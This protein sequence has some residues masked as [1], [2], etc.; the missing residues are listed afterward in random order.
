[1][2]ALQ[3][4]KN[5]L[6]PGGTRPRYLL[7]LSIVLTVELLFS[8]GR[9]LDDYSPSWNVQDVFFL[10]VLTIAFVNPI[11]RHP[12]WM[13]YGPRIM[14]A[15]GISVTASIS[16]LGLA[17]KAVL[18]YYVV[19]ASLGFLAERRNYYPSQYLSFFMVLTVVFM[20]ADLA[21][22]G[23]P[24]GKTGYAVLMGIGILTVGINVFLLRQDLLSND[25][26][27]AE[28]NKILEDMEELSRRMV[29][30][31]S[32]SQQVEPLMNSICLESAE[33]LRLDEVNIHLFDSEKDSLVLVGSSTL[34]SEGVGPEA[35][36]SEK[37]VA[38][39]KCYETGKPHNIPE[40][41]YSF[42]VDDNVMESQLVVPIILEDEVI[43][44]LDSKHSVKGFYQERHEL[45][46]FVIASFC[47]IKIKE[48]KANEFLQEAR[49][50]EEQAAY[51]RELA[52]LKERF[53]TNISHDLKTPLSL[54]KGP[55]QQLFGG[56]NDAE[57]RRL[58]GYIIKNAD[59]LLSMIGQLLDLNRLD[60]GALEVSS[61][62]LDLEKILQN[63]CTQYEGIISSQSIQFSTA[64]E[65]ARISIDRFRLEQILHNLLQNAFRYTQKG[66]DVSLSVSLES[67]ELHIVV[68]DNG[69]G[70]PE[71]L[72]SKV[73]DR[74]FKVDVNNHEGTGIGLSLVKEYANDLGGRAHVLSRLGQGSAFHVHLPLQKAEPNKSEQ[75]LIEEKSEESSNF[76]PVMLVVEDN[77][78]LNDFICSFFQEEYQCVS[79]FNGEEALQQMKEQT[80]DL[81]ITD[82]MM[83]YKSGETLVSEIRDVEEWSHIPI[84]VLTAKSDVSG[85]IS[86]YEKGIDNYLE[87]PFEVF[88]LKAIVDNTLMLRKAL[89]DKFHQH[90]QESLDA[91][92]RGD[93]KQ[94]IDFATKTLLEKLQQLVL[95]NL[96]NEGLTVPFLS[97][98]LGIGR[99]ALQREVKS[100]TGLTPSEF[101]RSL[102]LGEAKR[103]LQTQTY[104]VSEVAYAVGFN[105]L[106]YFSRSFKLEF[107]VLPS[108]LL[109]NNT[110]TK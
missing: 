2:K 23:N 34:E 48:F 43:G 32:Q 78:D 84:V 36:L 10:S 40:L 57:V 12:F 58:S 41:R 27:Y 30:V 96:Q 17:P 63:V 45:L 71:H 104:T 75:R 26:F 31:L 19:W 1:M 6:S 76:Q 37:A 4:L 95:T 25:N 90:L 59:H 101:I 80:P 3:L 18:M 49:K 44:V 14:N 77:R 107:G 8:V 24:P 89:R 64:Y 93:S 88:E 53:V 67:K 47:A 38:V 15:F 65:A 33:L 35:E 16:L 108:E 68:K 92:E 20:S 5:A 85:K 99:N 87:K 109:G 22:M 82:L 86:L 69:P 81:I 105:T 54:I 103:L 79:A 62:E 72:S 55:A 52:K 100:L 51:Y 61:T 74:F 46:F 60:R 13:E 9:N 73:F 11:V 83:P 91:N 50:V 56:Q 66:G 28:S 21:L 94:R 7:W 98:E 110:P 70:I 97:S 29:Q 39:Y 42:G 102:R 106:S